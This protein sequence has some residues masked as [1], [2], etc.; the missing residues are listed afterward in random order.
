MHQVVRPHAG[1]V[2]SKAVWLA[3]LIVC[4]NA[5]GNLS[6]AWG[7]KQI[8][9]VGFDPSGYLQAMLNPFV[10]A[11]I[12]LLILWLLTRMALMS[13]ADL[14]F[15]LPLMAIGYVVAAGLGK[16]VLHEEVGTRQWAG[17][18]LIFAGSA[19]VGTT[20]HRTSTG[21]GTK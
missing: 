16:L 9:T 2:K 15:V 1:P 11:G 21:P 10:A 4:F 13:W 17:T 6:L 3:C 7:M 18:V 20:H 14:S 12:G 5:I 8:S 19:L